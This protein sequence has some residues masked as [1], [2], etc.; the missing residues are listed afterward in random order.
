MNNNNKNQATWTQAPPTPL[1]LLSA[2][3][4]KYLALTTTGI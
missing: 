3:L 2:V 4:L 1:I